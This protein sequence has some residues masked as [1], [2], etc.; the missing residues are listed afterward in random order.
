MSYT[1]LREEEKEELRAALYW[2]GEDCYD[3]SNLSAAEKEI[4][5]N[6]ESPEDIPE[7]VMIS[8]Y[9]HYSFVEEDFFCNI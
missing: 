6:A 5:D 9:G 4:V 3:Y 2:G 8:A 7:E 1:E